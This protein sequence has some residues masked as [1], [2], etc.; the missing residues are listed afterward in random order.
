M[1]D[2]EGPECQKNVIQRKKKRATH[3][4]I[5]AHQFA[6]KVKAELPSE[7]PTIFGI[8][9]NLEFEPMDIWIQRAHID[10]FLIMH[11]RNW[12]SMLRADITQNME[13]LL[14]QAL[15]KTCI[16]QFTEMDGLGMIQILLE[17]F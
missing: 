8:R 3:K 2:F 17:M 6:C 13:K 12:D 9:E 4:L 11:P 10:H 16:F 5:T 1:D 15:E 14:D 7:E